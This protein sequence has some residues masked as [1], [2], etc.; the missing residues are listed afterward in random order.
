LEEC[1]ELIKWAF[2]AKGAKEERRSHGK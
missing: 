1:K 2:M